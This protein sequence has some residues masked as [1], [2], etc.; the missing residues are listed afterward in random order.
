MTYSTPRNPQLHFAA[1][2]KHIIVGSSC[3]SWYLKGKDIKY[4]III[5]VFKI[6][7]KLKKWYSILYHLSTVESNHSCLLRAKKKTKY[8]PGSPYTRKLLLSLPEKSVPPTGCGSSNFLQQLLTTLTAEMQMGNATPVAAI[9]TGEQPNDYEDDDNDG[10]ADEDGSDGD[11]DDDG[12]TY[13]AVRES[14]LAKGQRTQACEQRSLFHFVWPSIPID[15][16][17]ENLWRRK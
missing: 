9:S 10:V 17:N 7:D 16:D 8:H 13:E 15:N 2:K 3:A 12:A 14:W 11:G 1:R 6:F 4:P 5:F